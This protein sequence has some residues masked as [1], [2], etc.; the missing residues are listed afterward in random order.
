MKELTRSSRLRVSGDCVLSVL[1]DEA[2]LVP[3]SHSTDGQRGFVSLNATG[4]VLVRALDEGL[5]LGEAA[6]R[7]AEQYEDPDRQV[8]WSDSLSLIGHLVDEGLLTVCDE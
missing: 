2:L 5:T 1:A 6:E 8:I 4:S 7:L 3:V